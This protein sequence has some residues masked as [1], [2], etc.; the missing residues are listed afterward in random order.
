MD[1]PAASTFTNSYLNTGSFVLRTCRV[2]YPLE[3]MIKKRVPVLTLKNFNKVK[4]RLEAVFLSYDVMAFIKV[5]A[6]TLS[7][8]GIKEYLFNEL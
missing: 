1:I 4:L 7:S 6:C 2:H 5:Y 8:S 3:Y